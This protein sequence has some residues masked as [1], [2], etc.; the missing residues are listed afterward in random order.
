MQTTE[1]TVQ[2]S[3]IRDFFLQSR[4]KA[5]KGSVKAFLEKEKSLT[6]LLAQLI[7]SI[8]ANGRSKLSI[9]AYRSLKGEVALED[10]CIS[11]GFS[12]CFP[13]LVEGKIYFYPVPSKA[14]INTNLKNSK[15][16]S[17]SNLGFFEP[18]SNDLSLDIIPKIL[19]IPGL[20]F[21]KNFMR[22][23]FGGGFYDKFLQD[24]KGI[25]IGI[26]FSE[27]ISVKNLPFEDHDVAMDFI[28]TDECIL[29]KI[30][31]KSIKE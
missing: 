20:A 18:V 9:G 8:S 6:A 24:Y 30:N 5:V 13:K 31:K 12:C 10:F 22:L 2:K 14:L 1:P 28:V 11:L 3:V 26:S 25:K 27:A 4:Q 16:W 21:D 7:K 29:Q 23:G 17:K 19:L 15:Y